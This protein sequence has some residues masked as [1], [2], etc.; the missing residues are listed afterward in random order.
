MA[1]ISIGSGK[2]Y[3]FSQPGNSKLIVTAHGGKTQNKFQLPGDSTIWFCSRHGLSTRT[4]ADDIATALTGD[5]QREGQI[6]R[7]AFHPY[8]YKESFDYELSKFA[9][10]HG[11]GEYENYKVYA[12]IAKKGI[13]ILSPRNR[14]FNKDV[15]LSFALDS[16]KKNNYKNIYMSFC[17]S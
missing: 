13:D 3:L 14:W 9:G 4:D 5:T 11:G 17:R 15:L 10:K 2:M 16:I 6:R 12:K 1:K 7:D 8:H